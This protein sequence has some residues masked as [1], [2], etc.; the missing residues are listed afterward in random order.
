MIGLGAVAHGP[1]ARAAVRPSLVLFDEL[2]PEGRA[3]AEAVAAGHPVGVGPAMTEL[4]DLAGHNGPDLILGLTSDPVAMIA[5]QMLAE[6][7]AGLVFRWRHH[8]RNGGWHHDTDLSAATLGH[9]GPCW[10]AALASLAGDRI[11]GTAGPLESCRS[12]GGTLGGNSRPLLVS[13]AFKTRTLP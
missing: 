6:A 3:F 10:P 5:S 11:S 12:P 13:W 4:F 8:F 7:G 2:V 1:A 9:A